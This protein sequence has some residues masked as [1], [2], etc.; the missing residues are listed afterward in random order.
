MS[1]MTPLQLAQKLDLPEV[2]IEALRNFKIDE[3]T[4][5]RLKSAF[6]EGPEAFEAAVRQEPDADVLVL[7]LYMRWG[8]DTHYMYAIRGMLWDIFFD[9]FKD[10]TLWS[11][12]FTEETGKPGLKHWAWCA[13]AIQMKV[14]RLGRLEFEPD[15]LSEDLVVGEALYPAGTRVL[16]VH[17]P[18]GEK[19]S[20]EAVEDSLGQALPFF[21]MYYRQEYELLRCCSWLLS[22]ALEELL[23]E[24]SNIRQ[25][26]GRFE[27]CGTYPER[28]A[29]ERVF[30]RLLEDPAQYPEET[31]LQKNLKKHLIS[32]GKAEMGC[33]I[34]LCKD[35]TEAY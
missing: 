17:I 15:T 32:G 30:G 20:P 12:A 21:R 5:A 25:F 22:P 7:A 19:L 9:T 24:N 33:G 2:S 35:I 13:K 10:L 3:A 11:H 16:N 29:E 1:K 14:F 23:D 34:I 8:M 4:A 31:T 28:Q 18:A 27:I 26:A 6:Q